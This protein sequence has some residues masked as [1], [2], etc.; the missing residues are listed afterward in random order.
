MPQTELLDQSLHAFPA[1]MPGEPLGFQN[2][3]NIL[4][5]RQLPEHRWL[6]RKVTDP[7]VSGPQIHGNVGDV[8]LIDQNPSR[9][10]R[11]ETD[12][13]VEGCRLTGSVGTE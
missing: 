3:E 11:R 2:G 12:N 4:L 1:L 8:G 13:H 7:V 10:G 9:I 6:L 5:N